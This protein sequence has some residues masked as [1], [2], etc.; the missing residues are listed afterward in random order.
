MLNTTLHIK[1]LQM[2]TFSIFF[3]AS[4]ADRCKVAPID[5]PLSTVHLF[6]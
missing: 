4:E 3:Y 1:I 6:V 5:F 2:L